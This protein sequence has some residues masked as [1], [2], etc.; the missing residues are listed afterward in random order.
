MYSGTTVVTKWVFY[1]NCLNFRLIQWIFFWTC[2]GSWLLCGVYTSKILKFI[3][4]G[5]FPY[6]VYVITVSLTRYVP[7][8]SHCEGLLLWLSFRKSFHTK[9][10]TKLQLFQKSELTFYCAHCTQT[11]LA[12]IQEPPAHFALCFAVMQ[13]HLVKLCF[14]LLYPAAKVPFPLTLRFKPMLQQG[15]ELLTLDASW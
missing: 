9:I 15:I 6:T 13:C 5:L 12:V 3:V 10:N 2:P 11:A 4:L 1:W 8:H 7:F 14:F